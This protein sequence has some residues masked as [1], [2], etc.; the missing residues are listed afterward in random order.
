VPAL[1]QL[2]ACWHALGQEEVA[3]AL[4][5]RAEAL[6]TE[7]EHLN[8]AWVAHLRASVHLARGEFEAAERPL[9]AALEAYRTAGDSGGEIK[10]AALRFRL[11]FERG[12]FEEALAVARES[13]EAAE[14]A[15]QQRLR[16]M[17]R[18]EEGRVLLAL[19]EEAAGLAAL[20]DA[21]SQSIAAGDSV[22]QFYAHYY[23]WKAHLGRKDKAAAD[24]D[25]H[26]CQYHVRFLAEATPQV[27]EVRKTM[28]SPT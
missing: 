28:R 5:V 15:G 1:V 22:L 7:G 11:L 23:L 26:A 18:I 12:S 14:R 25:L 19:G 16:T 6:L 27:L 3:L 10:V 9:H 20:N 24:L 8:R 4:V 21:L 2:A 17:R 13:R